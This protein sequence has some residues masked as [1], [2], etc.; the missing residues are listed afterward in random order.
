[1]KKKFRKNL[2]VRKL[3]ETFAA[4]KKILERGEERERGLKKKF[5][6]NLESEI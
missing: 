5:T 3:I 6:K 2:E 4:R 1:M